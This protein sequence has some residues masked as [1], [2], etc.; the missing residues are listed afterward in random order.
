MQGGRR[1]G[2]SRDGRSLR[3][4]R[5][6]ACKCVDLQVATIVAQPLV[7]PIEDGEDVKMLYDNPR[8]Q[9]TLLPQAYVW[10]SRL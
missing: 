3:E 9:K 10:R 7:L 4:A 1:F 2:V 8:V 5:A 6:C